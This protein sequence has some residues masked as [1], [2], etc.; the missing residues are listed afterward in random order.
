MEIVPNLPIYIL[1]ENI[2]HHEV[3]ITKKIIIDNGVELPLCVVNPTGDEYY[4]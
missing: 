4:K 3:E 2:L 1:V